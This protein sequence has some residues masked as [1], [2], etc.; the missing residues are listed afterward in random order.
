[1]LERAHELALEMGL[2]RVEAMTCA[3]R[4]RLHREKGE[5]DAALALSE[6]AM[7]LLERFG[8]ELSDRIVIAGTHALVLRTLERESEARP[9]IERLTDRVERENA[10]LASPLHRLRH[11]RATERL[12][13]AVLSPEGPVYPRV[14]V[15]DL[16]T[17]ADPVV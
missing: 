12:I 14:R 13:A 2:N 9:I 10:R 17:P 4:A 1:M 16:R 11:T 5:L 7:E 15:D 6:H 8:A 3:L